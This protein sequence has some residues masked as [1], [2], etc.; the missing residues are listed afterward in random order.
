LQVFRSILEIS[1]NLIFQFKLFI[2][3]LLA[4][5]IEWRQEVMIM[6]TMYEK[7]Q[8]VSKSID[9][10][11]EHI[12]QDKNDGMLLFKVLVNYLDKTNE[13]NLKYSRLNEQILT[14]NQLLKVYYRDI[15]AYMADVASGEE[16]ASEEF[17]TG[18]LAT[19]FGV[20]ITTINNWIKEGRF[21]GFK[22]EEENKQAK[23]KGTTLW[24]ART[25]KAYPV[26]E[27]VDEWR[28][29]NNETEQLEPE[30]KVFLI[31]QVAAFEIK[32]KGSFDQTLGRKTLS[33]MSAQEESDSSVWR[34]FQKRLRDDYGL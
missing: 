22:R 17:S 10:L 4:V 15:L 13:N 8:F 32:Y 9:S 14:D 5:C 20:S 19:Y 21:I 3:S 6:F 31:N 18:Q 26:Q 2:C 16:V 33:E 34:Y 11:T 1:L 12:F 24:K 29:E 30:E 27:I 7:T 23:I 28:K 25:G